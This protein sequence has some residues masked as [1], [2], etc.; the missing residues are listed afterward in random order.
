MRLFDNFFILRII[1]M[2]QYFKQLFCTICM[3]EFQNPKI[4][5]CGHTF[6]EKCIESIS[7]ENEV[8]CRQCINYYNLKT[9]QL[10][11]NFSLINLAIEVQN[12]MSSYKKNENLIEILKKKLDKKR[13]KIKDLINKT[14]NSEEKVKKLA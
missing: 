9:I 6:C 2:N 14:L 13:E 5:P 12:F 3:T 11:F 7:F 10:S 8:K 1:T 4:L